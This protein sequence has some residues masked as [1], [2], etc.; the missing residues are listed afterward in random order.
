MT[1]SIESNFVAFF[2]KWKKKNENSFW[3]FILTL[4][5]ENVSILHGMLVWRTLPLRVEQFSTERTRFQWKMMCQF[6][7]KI[8]IIQFATNKMHC[9]RKHKFCK[10]TTFQWHRSFSHQEIAH[11]WC[12]TK[13]GFSPHIWHMYVY[14]VIFKFSNFQNVIV[15]PINEFIFS[16][17]VNQ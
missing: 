4:S 12:M 6:N 2:I 9:N 1:F 5:P 17:I 7:M 10:L 16:K 15:F 3:L 11:M 8:F 14:R 13:Y